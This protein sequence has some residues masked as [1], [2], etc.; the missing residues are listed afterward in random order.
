[1]LVSGD[2]GTVLVKPE[3]ERLQSFLSRLQAAK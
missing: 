1:M 2:P 3:H